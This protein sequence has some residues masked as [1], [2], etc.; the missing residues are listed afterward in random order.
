MVAPYVFAALVRPVLLEKLGTGLGVA[1]RVLQHH[2]VGFHREPEVG[3]LGLVVQHPAN[4]VRD[5]TA[6]PVALHLD[7]RIRGLGKGNGA[8]RQAAVRH[9]MNADHTVIVQRAF[10]RVRRDCHFSCAAHDCRPAA[11][12]REDRG[13]EDPEDQADSSHLHSPHV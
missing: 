12:S 1:G 10:G 8:A 13:E 6:Q 3:V 7:I 9:D 11:A 5:V 2:P 4:Q